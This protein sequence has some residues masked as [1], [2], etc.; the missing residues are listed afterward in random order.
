M[1]KLR[2]GI[3]GVG[4]RGL[5]LSHLL[6]GMK[7]A[8]IVSVCDLYEEKRNK[9]VEEIGQICGV[10][11]KSC[12][13]YHDILAAKDIDAV[14]IATS[15]ETHVP[16]AIES[17]KA[18]KITAIEVGGAYCIEDCWKLVRAYQETKTPFMFLE[19][20]CYG[21]FELLATALARSGKLGTIVHCH[22]AYGH[23]IRDE[24]MGGRINKH[25][26]LKHY[27]EN[28]CENYPT[29]DLGPCAR[30]LNINRG[31]KMC[32]LV[33]VASKAAG[34]EEYARSSRNMDPTLIGQKFAQGDIVNTI[35]SCE[36]GSTISLKLDTTLPRFYSREFTVRGTKGLCLQDLNAIIIEGENEN[37]HE[38]FDPEDS[39]K[40][41]INS[42]EKFS[43]RFLP[44]IWRGIDK[45]KL[46]TG[47]GGMDYLMLCE[48]V[49]AAREG[50]EMPIDVY[51]AASWMAITALSK[52]SIAGH[53]A[54]VEI[55]D[56]T[57]GKWRTRNREDVVPLVFE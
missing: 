49:S 6:A 51:D 15:W 47:H 18:K 38:F 32:S 46:K 23:D 29:H 48:F 14:L 35:I 7:E 3:I 5:L 39:S 26:R 25:Y 45:E 40:K 1:D 13:D 12:S 27:I 31:N 21:R 54:S 8:M 37:L 34:L 57:E 52:Q 33:S 43:D 28:N 41:Y 17:L 55:P 16:I 44:A 24:V 22:G 9:A 53:G 56:F 2:L 30:L 20:C 11:P 36:D 4:N 19:N 10:R 50:K 42:A